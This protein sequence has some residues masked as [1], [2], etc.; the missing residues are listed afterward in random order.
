MPPLSRFAT[1]PLD[2][3]LAER[4]RQNIAD[5][6]RCGHRPIQLQPQHI[7]VASAVGATLQ[8]DDLCVGLLKIK[9]VSTGTFLISLF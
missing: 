9:K 5:A 2:G 7:G 1:A 8:T 6:E 3:S 4:S